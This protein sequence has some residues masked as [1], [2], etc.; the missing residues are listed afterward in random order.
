MALKPVTVSQL[1]EY[2]SRVIGTDP[3]LGA[4]VVK[5]E[6]SNLKYHGS[7]HV[8]FSIIDAT[9][10]I[11]CFLPRDY[12]MSLHYPL[13]DGMEVTLTGSVSV[14]KKNGTYS[15]YVKIV[16]V[17]GE[18]NLAIAFEKMKEKLSKEGLFDQSHKKPIPKYPN[19]IG[20]VTSATGAAVKDILKILKGRNHL[21]DV[22]IFPVLVQG[23]AASAD[24]AAMLDYINENFDDIDTLIVGRGG[25]S[26]DDLWAFN[27][28]NVARAIYRSEIP[29]ISAVGHEIDF[30]IADLVADLRAETP[31]AAA[32][33]VVPDTEQMRKQMEDLKEHLY[34]QLSNKLM[35]HR[36]LID[37]LAKEM[38]NCLNGQI[39]KLENELTQSKLLLEENNPTQILENGY[40]VL[41][42]E[43]GKV[44]SAI[45]QLCEKQEYKI[46][47]QDGF[48]K[49]RITEIGG[50]QR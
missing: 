9:S 33:L 25:G 43:D 41:T 26:A 32:Q 38:K 19:K 44:I 6:I 24:I 29:I 3:L 47:L 28:E 18:G 8:Y 10:K 48:A 15:L 45:S 1:N 39:A 21:V 40:S 2:I 14:F 12:A 37:N 5:G 35:Y 23:E 20:I 50:N 7:G 16:E 49:C 27:E 13:E 30:T 11:N 17:S 42:D 34:I 4:V 46:T 22:M 31:T 36:L